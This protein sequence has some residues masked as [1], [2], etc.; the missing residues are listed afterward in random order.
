MNKDEEV[1]SNEV[2]KAK[3]EDK[4]FRKKCAYYLTFY[5]DS[6]VIYHDCD[7]LEEPSDAD[8]GLFHII[9]KLTSPFNAAINLYK[10][11]DRIHEASAFRS[12]SHCFIRRFQDKLSK[13]PNLLS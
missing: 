10:S 1:E 6:N 13:F 2:K 11:R 4:K 5:N 9:L 3:E 8:M 7:N 12:S